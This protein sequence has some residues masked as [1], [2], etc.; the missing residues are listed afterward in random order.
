[1][2]DYGEEHVGD[3]DVLPYVV[4]EFVDGQPLS[5]LLDEGALPWPAVIDIVAQTAAALSVAHAAGLVH[6]DIKPGNIMVTGD[7]VKLIDFGLAASVGASDLDNGQL[8]GTAAYLAPERIVDA[9]VS[10][11]ADVYALGVVLYRALTGRLPWAD[12]DTAA[13]LRAHLFLDPS[14]LVDV[15]NRPRLAQLCAACLDKDPNHRPT[16]AELAAQLTALAASVAPTAAIAPA[17][18]PM[19]D[20]PRPAR[21]AARHV[22]T[23]PYSISLALPGSPPWSRR[24]KVAAAIIG[25]GL[26]VALLSVP[27]LAGSP[28]RSG[29][30]VPEAVAPTCRADFAITRDWGSGFTATLSVTN[31][32]GVA[33]P[34]WDVAF[35]FGGDQTLDAPSASQ[36]VAADPG[37]SYVV[38]VSQNGQRV[39]A[40]T[41]RDLAP[42]QTVTVPISARYE[43]ANPIPTQFELNGRPCTSTVAGAATPPT[44]APT[45][46]DLPDGNDGGN[47]G[48]GKGHHGDG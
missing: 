10:A 8:F 43:A 23:R 30:S 9:P 35:S 31:D 34:A 33:V 18:P 12:E 32:S 46:P 14:P 17:P 16:S 25:G 7:G 42:H 41:T 5:R 24:R 44:I 11:A 1:V 27:W 26:C 15:A 4:M 38:P 45:T 19:L 2:Y 37:P 6:R 13:L 21:F 22:A 40:G 28:A 39:V 29:Y 3:G 48:H 47:H 20:P 36:V